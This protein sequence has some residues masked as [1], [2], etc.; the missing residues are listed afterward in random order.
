MKTVFVAL[1]GLWLAAVSVSAQAGIALGRTRVVF[2][3]GE[4]SR[5]LKLSNDGEDV[6][7]VQAGV[8]TWDGQKADDTFRVQPPL[9]RLEARGNNLLRVTYSGKPLPQDRESVF[10]LELNAIPSGAPD[11]GGEALRGRVAASL[12][13]GIKLFYRPKGLPSSPDGAWGSLTFSRQAGQLVVKNPSPFYLTLAELSVGTK[14]VAFGSGGPEQM[15]APFGQ[16]S[17]PLAVPAGA[18][19]AW[20]VISDYGGLS[21]PQKG[22][23]E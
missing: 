9:F 13:V 19:V 11:A 16:V 22:R 20:T 7:L 2:A 4:T 18:P 14:G 1:L 12:G 23:V 8:R 6:Y 3:G 21:T 10:R 15:I 5:P 17:Y